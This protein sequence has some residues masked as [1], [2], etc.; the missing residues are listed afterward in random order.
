MPPRWRRKTFLPLPL[1]NFPDHPRFATLQP[2]DF[3]RKAEAMTKPP[4]ARPDPQ[5]S[6]SA[7]PAP[8]RRVTAVLGLIL[9]CCLIE[10]TLTLSDHGLIG[11]SHLRGLAYQ[12][13]GFWTGLLHNWQPNFALQPVTMFFT[14]AFLHAGLLHLSMNMI[15]LWSIGL[16]ITDRVGQWRFLLIYLVSL[17]GGAIAFGLLSSALRPMVGASGALF[18]LVGAWLAW[19]TIERLAERARLRP[20][21]WSVFWLT[22]LN[23]VLWWITGGQLAWET[24]LGGALA[25]ALVALV[26]R[27][28]DLATG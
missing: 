24:H 7:L 15:T 9:I 4:D 6:P 16:A 26:I 25:G 20:V 12:N 21:L 19:E 11:P 1:A 14:Y 22:M 8:R 5:T 3:W 17:L 28:A 10:F 23:V 2:T 13:G 27:P 18:G